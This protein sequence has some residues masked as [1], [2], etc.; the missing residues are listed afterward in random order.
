[1]MMN[2][3]VFLLIIIMT[4]IGSSEEV[5][6]DAACYPVNTE[7]AILLLLL[8]L[9]YNTLHYNA[10]DTSHSTLQLHSYSALDTAD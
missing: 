2:I 6:R 5:S 8:N 9:H 1:M 7:L 10:L 4:I 3:I